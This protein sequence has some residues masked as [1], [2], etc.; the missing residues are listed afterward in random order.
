MPSSL[1]A[2][3]AVVVPD[4]TGDGACPTLDS[5]GGGDA[6]R[7]KDRAVAKLR[8]LRHAPFFFRALGQ[9]LV[10]A[11]AG[12]RRRQRVGIAWREKPTEIGILLH[13]AQ[14]LDILLPI[15]DVLRRTPGVRLGLFIVPR[16][17]SRSPRV[18]RA[19]IERSITP[20]ALDARLL[21]LGAARV[22]KHLD[23]LLTASET[24]HGQHRTAHAIVRAAHDAGVE[25]Y[26]L[27]HGVE[28]VGLSYVD[29]GTAASIAF[30]SDHVLTWASPARLP[31]TI[32][33]ATRDKCIP[34][35]RPRA[36]RPA[37]VRLPAEIL[38]R[39]LIGVFENLHW[40]RYT[41]RFRECFVDDLLAF[42][43][44]RPDLTVLVKPHFSSHMLAKILAESKPAPPNLVFAD[45]KSP[46]WEPFT[47][48]AMIPHCRAVVTT[49]STV[50][51]D[52]AEL[53]VPVAVAR[54]G[55]DLPAFEGLPSL[56]GL[57]GWLDFVDRAIANPVAA[58][59]ALADFRDRVRLPGD[60]AERVARVLVAGVAK[61]D[62]RP[63]LS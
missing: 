5:P 62:V 7:A 6:W 55:L 41:A 8:R 44:A 61:A 35:G 58:G 36:A 31:A 49:P 18:V 19:L 13:L 24:T 50:A 12:P 29:A 51:L 30:A 53:N 3:V 16:L 14:D 9:C 21:R 39:P 46:K 4:A 47:A 48:A 54:Y 23:C 40:N 33:S 1:R 42:C 56:A 57:T 2:S 20:A 60:A 38:E 34:V 22:L 59:A 52:A 45:P 37:G 27:Q 32:G 63:L 11:L 26:T 25:T 28:N 15:I 17:I 43:R 10:Q